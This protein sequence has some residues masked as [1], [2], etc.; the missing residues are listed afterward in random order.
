MS[1]FIYYIGNE[2]YQLIEYRINVIEIFKNT[3]YHLYSFNLN[4]F[5]FNFI[6]ASRLTLSKL[7]LFARTESVDAKDQH[8]RFLGTWMW[9]HFTITL[10]RN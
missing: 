5:L 3:L 1:V 9:E 10:N 4:Y 6:I 2:I 8:F 7:L